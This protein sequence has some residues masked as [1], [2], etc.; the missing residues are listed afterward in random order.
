LNPWHIRQA[1]RTVCRGGVIAYPTEAVYGLGCQPWSRSAIER[2]LRLKRRPPTRGL[3]LIAST[4][5]QIE[6]L[7][8]FA[9]LDRRRVMD[10]WPGPV[11]WLLPPSPHVPEWVL[12]EG[13]AVAVRVT[14]YPA[15]R[16]ICDLTGP[17][18]STSANPGGRPPARSALR[19]R[20]YFRAGLD[21]VVPGTAGGGRAPS[22]IRD[23]RTGAILRQG[24]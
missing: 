3:I 24:G 17:I 7:V 4:V 20:A 15:A 22:E 2:I 19:V 9:G 16:A 11:T 14:A 10:T 8:R 18:V 6:P 5:E 21:Y 23:G 13:G 1:A 12:G